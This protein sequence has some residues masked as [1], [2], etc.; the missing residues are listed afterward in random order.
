MGYKCCACEKDFK[1]KLEYCIPEGFA[2]NRDHDNKP[3]CDRCGSEPTPT[4]DEICKKLDQDI[5]RRR[6][7]AQLEK[8]RSTKKGKGKR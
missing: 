4:L 2:N 8:K 3:L 6:F 7:Y 1:G 5:W